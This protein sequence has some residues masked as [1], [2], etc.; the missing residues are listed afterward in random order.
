MTA[1]PFLLPEEITLGTRNQTVRA[2]G[3]RGGGKK[4]PSQRK[5]PESLTRLEEI[6]RAGPASEISPA[7]YISRTGAASA[8]ATER[9]SRQSS[10]ANVRIMDFRNSSP[11]RRSGNPVKGARLRRGV[12]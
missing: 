10:H 4:A 2:V 9:R 5:F 1:T 8:A 6:F 11:G 7:H 3:S 12:N